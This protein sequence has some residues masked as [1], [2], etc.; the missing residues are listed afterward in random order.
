MDDILKSRKATGI[1]ALKNAA[2][3]LKKNNFS[4]SAFSTGAEAA[5]YI[6]QMVGTGKQAGFGGSVTIKTLGLIEKLQAAG[7][8]IITHTPGM[9]RETKIETWLKAQSSD[10]YFASPQAVTMKGELVMLDG[11][12]NRVAA[13]VYGP[14]KVVLIAGVNKLINDLEKGLWRTRNISAIANNIR[15][16]RN[17]P[18]VKTGKCEDCDSPERICNV[19]TVFHKKPAMTD[20]EVV[21]ID[22]ELGY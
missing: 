4:C 14:K 11:N 5:D 2:I 12:G 6:L 1:E 10:F 17:N 8:T 21:L 13:C 19:L 16:R 7:N 20:I 18:C 15:L 22:E 9:D 3:A